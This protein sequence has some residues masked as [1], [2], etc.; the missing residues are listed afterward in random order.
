M[1]HTVRFQRILERAEEIAKENGLECVD[2]YCFT[3]AMLDG[4][5][6]NM[7]YLA[8]L[9][10]GINIDSFIMELD[11]LN[12]MRHPTSQGSQ[13]PDSAPFIEKKNEPPPKTSP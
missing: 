6:Y 11:K 1:L 7:C 13:A 2:S 3:K 8:F 10:L 4:T 9:N 5:I 12:D